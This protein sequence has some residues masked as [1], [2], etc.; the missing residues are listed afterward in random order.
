MEPLQPH[1]T[2]TAEQAGARMEGEAAALPVVDRPAFQEAHRRLAEQ[3]DIIL[4]LINDL[5]GIILDSSPMLTP[6]RQILNYVIQAFIGL[7][8]T[9]YGCSRVA[10]TKYASVCFQNI[11]PEMMVRAQEGKAEDEAEV[12]AVF[13]AQ[14]PIFKANRDCCR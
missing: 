7:M 9:R 2:D 14:G 3:E 8:E 13:D 12:N 6:A 1:P 5:V 4:N 11:V 10:A